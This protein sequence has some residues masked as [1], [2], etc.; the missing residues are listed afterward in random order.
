MVYKRLD[1]EFSPITVPLEL[2]HV[3]HEDSCN[4]KVMQLAEAGL[5]P[6]DKTSQALPSY[7]ETIADRCGVETVVQV[8]SFITRTGMDAYKVQ[9]RIALKYKE[10]RRLVYKLGLT[11]VSLCVY[12]EYG[13]GSTTIQH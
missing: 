5:M 1:Y 13:G 11:W 9:L 2:T 4:P 10:V 8:E 6:A 3:D 12:R 7:K